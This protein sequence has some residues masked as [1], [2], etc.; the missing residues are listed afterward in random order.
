MDP[1]RRR[2]PRRRGIRAWRYGDRAGLCTLERV[3]EREFWQLLEEVLGRGYGRA[4]A[5]DQ[6]LDRLDGM[7]AIEA[8][9]A[10][11]EPRVVW[12]VLCDQ[13]NIP[14]SRRWGKGHN[15]PPMP[16]R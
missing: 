7:T 4:L 8:L 16:V 3:Q 2:L 1:R 14:D 9:D 12:N 5:H 15:A 6:V 11:E 13:M 10:G